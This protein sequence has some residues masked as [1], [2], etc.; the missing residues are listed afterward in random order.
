MVQY[1]RNQQV[2]LSQE[3]K[4]N[5][6]QQQQGIEG[7]EDVKKCGSRHT[8]FGNQRIIPDTKVR[9]Q[10]LPLPLATPLYTW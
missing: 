8:E 1:D 10:S 4:G 7:D 5:G 2:Q 3:N 9:Q 6:M